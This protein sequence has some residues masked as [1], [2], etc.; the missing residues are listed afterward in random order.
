MPAWPL[1]SDVPLTLVRVLSWRAHQARMEL[2]SKFDVCIVDEKPCD[3]Y[4]DVLVSKDYNA[5]AKYGWK[6]EMVYDP[7]LP[8]PEKG[9]LHGG[10]RATT[11]AMECWLRRSSSLIHSRCPQLYPEGWKEY[12]RCC[13]EYAESKYVDL[14]LKRAILTCEIQAC[15]LSPERETPLTSRRIYHRLLGEPWLNICWCFVWTLVQT[16]MI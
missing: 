12:A 4:V 15:S 7:I 5:L 8:T 9:V 14:D 1:R 10:L 16:K 3:E 11:D 2:P 13:R 6:R